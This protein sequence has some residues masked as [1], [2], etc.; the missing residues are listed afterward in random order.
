MKRFQVTVN[1]T[2]YDVTVEEV[3]AD[4]TTQPQQSLPVTQQTAAPKTQGISVKAPMPG[5]VL[6]IKTTVG[7]SVKAGQV[8]VVLEAMKMENEI[9]S[10]K[11][12]TVTAVACT[13]GGAVNAEDVLIVI[14]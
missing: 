8:L 11:D 7:S 9:V 4:T 5:T 1:G 6:D 14:A 3:A 13:K 12:G 2:A 10:P